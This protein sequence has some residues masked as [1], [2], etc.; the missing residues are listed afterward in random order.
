MVSTKIKVVQWTEVFDT[1]IYPA[2][3]IEQAIKAY[4]SL[5]TFKTK[6]LAKKIE[7]TAQI[8]AEGDYHFREE[9]ANYVLGMTIKCK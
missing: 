5:G 7:V 6:Q 8:P 3:A 1:R 4:A 2:K 9:F